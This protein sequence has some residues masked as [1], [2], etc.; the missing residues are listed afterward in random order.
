M[1][2]GTVLL[3]ITAFLLPAFQ[4]WAQEKKP[5]PVE[6]KNLI[7]KGDQDWVNTGIKLLPKDL[8]IVKASGNVCFS[9]K[10]SPACTDPNGWDVE[11]YEDY[12][13]DDYAY[14]FDPIKE[15]NHAAL[16]GNVGSDTF[17]IGKGNK[18]K[19]KEGVLYL[20]INDCTLTEEIF[21]NTGEFEVYIRVERHK[22]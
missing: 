1:K 3:L 7:M 5:P 22:K 15:A 20:G 8:V 10:A 14:C 11:T 19:G 4:L 17:F 6:E 13:G 18:F 2:K 21:Y 16:I 12:W 9:G